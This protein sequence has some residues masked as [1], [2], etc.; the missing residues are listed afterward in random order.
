[1]FF[2]AIIIQHHWLVQ[3]TNPPQKGKRKELKNDLREI[4]LQKLPS[5]HSQMNR[6]MKKEI[7]EEEKRRH[8]VLVLTYKSE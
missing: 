3:C 8:I 1:M 5:H 7:E 6:V 2:V 4:W